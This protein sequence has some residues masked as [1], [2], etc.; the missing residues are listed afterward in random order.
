MERISKFDDVLKGRKS[1][2][3]FDTEYKIRKE[4]LRCSNSWRKRWKKSSNF[5]DRSW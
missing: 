4:K 2:K 3:V 5:T 1:V